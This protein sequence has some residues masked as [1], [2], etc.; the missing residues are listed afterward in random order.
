MDNIKIMDN[1]KSYISRE[2]LINEREETNVTKK[3][4]AID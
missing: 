2:D 1:I 3:W 4:E